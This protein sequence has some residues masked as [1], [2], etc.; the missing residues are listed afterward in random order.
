MLPIIHTEGYMRLGLIAARE[1]CGWTQERLAK[2]IGK[3]DRSSIAHYEKGECGIPYPVL[4]KLSEVLK[5]P[6]DVLFENEDREV[7]TLKG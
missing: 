7:V 5:T 4:K 6:M 2:E 1:A 3:A